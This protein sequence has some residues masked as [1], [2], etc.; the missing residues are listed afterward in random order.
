MEEWLGRWVGGF[1][2]REEVAA[3]TIAPADDVGERDGEG[4]VSRSSIA[5]RWEGWRRMRW[6][7][8]A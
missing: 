1:E 7:P 5:G 4:L 8:S 2:E 3:W 6:D